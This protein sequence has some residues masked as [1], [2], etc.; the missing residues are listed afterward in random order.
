M[1]EKDFNEPNEETRARGVKRSSEIK[2]AEVTTSKKKRSKKPPAESPE[3]AQVE[4][5][6]NNLKEQSEESVKRS[7]MFEAVTDVAE[8]NISIEELMVALNHAVRSRQY[9]QLAQGDHHDDPEDTRVIELNMAAFNKSAAAI[10]RSREREAA[11]RRYAS[12]LPSSTINHA[13][14]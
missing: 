8:G 5:N 10:A 2:I 12:S 9:R 1:V 7:R 6:F 14:G 3:P 13:Y 4:I 11:W